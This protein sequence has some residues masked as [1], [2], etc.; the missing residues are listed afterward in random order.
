MEKPAQDGLGFDDRWYRVSTIIISHR[1]AAA[2]RYCGA[3]LHLYR[4]CDRGL[5]RIRELG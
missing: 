3:V 2:W 4:R 1:F 5:Y